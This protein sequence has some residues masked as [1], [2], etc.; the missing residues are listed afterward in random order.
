ME[1]Y[2]FLLFAGSIAIIVCALAYFLIASNNKNVDKL[3]LIV[4]FGFA[5]LVGTIVAYSI[6]DGSNSG[7]KDNKWV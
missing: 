1:F 5:L 2:Y 3:A 7:D 6:Q 4:A